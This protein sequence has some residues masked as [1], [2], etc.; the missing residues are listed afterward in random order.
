MHAQEF[1]SEV[2]G[3]LDKV[4]FPVKGRSGDDS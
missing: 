2:T 3:G 4:A 1:A